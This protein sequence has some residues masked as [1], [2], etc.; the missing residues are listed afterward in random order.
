MADMKSKEQL[1]FKQERTC[2]FQLI[3]KAMDEW[4]E[5][6]QTQANQNE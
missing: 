1:H 5:F 6:D 3:Q 2:P 4:I